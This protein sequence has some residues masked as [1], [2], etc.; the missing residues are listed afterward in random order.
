L[1]LSPPDKEERDS[2]EDKQTDPD[3]A[4]YPVGRRKEGFI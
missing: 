2:H 4:E 3:W 1:T